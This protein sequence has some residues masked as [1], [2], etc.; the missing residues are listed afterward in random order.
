MLPTLGGQKGGE[1]HGT[2]NT[3]KGLDCTGIHVR[4][5]QATISKVRFLHIVNILQSYLY[6]HMLI[7]INKIVTCLL[8]A[9]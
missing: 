4:A 8:C 6:V 7:I 5:V 3:G 9:G 2:V 1:P